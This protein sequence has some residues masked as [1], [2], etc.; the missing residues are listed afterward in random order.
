ML[1]DA[2]N[3]YVSYSSRLNWA[4]TFKL[5]RKLLYK[6]DRIQRNSW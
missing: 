3:V 6:I 4:E 5:I 1:E 2:L